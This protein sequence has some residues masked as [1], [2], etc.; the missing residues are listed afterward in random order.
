MAI[1]DDRFL[2]VFKKTATPF[3]PTRH[4][5]AAVNLHLHL[6]TVQ[7]IGTFLGNFPVTAAEQAMSIEK[8]SRS[9]QIAYVFGD[10]RARTV[11][12]VPPV[13]VPHPAHAKARANLPIAEYREQ[14]LAAIQANQV[15]V[16]SG[17]TGSGELQALAHLFNCS[18]FG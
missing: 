9:T 2:T 7:Q 14:I 13:V 10:G 1:G 5:G 6:D 12:K 18:A 3:I 16:V 11:L 15:V 17:E 8:H 4:S